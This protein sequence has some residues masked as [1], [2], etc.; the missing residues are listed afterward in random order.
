MK[1]VK[2][3]VKNGTKST[4]NVIIRIG[5]LLSVVSMLASSV[6]IYTGT[7]GIEPKLIIIPMTAYGITKLIQAFLNSNN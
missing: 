2:S 5:M 3:K 4:Y 7:E 6:I 1:E